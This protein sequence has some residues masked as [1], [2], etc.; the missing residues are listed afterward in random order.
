MGIAAKPSDAHASSGKKQSATG[1][2]SKIADP[3]LNEQQMVDDSIGIV[4]GS[5][6]KI[7]FAL[8]D[9]ELESHHTD[10]F[11]PGPGLFLD[12]KAEERI[13]DSSSSI[14]ATTTRQGQST[15]MPATFGDVGPAFED[16]HE[17][18]RWGLESSSAAAPEEPDWK[19]LERLAILRQE[20]THSR[21]DDRSTRPV[22]VLSP[23]P[24]TYSRAAGHPATVYH[25]SSG[26][27]STV[28]SRS[29]SWYNDLYRPISLQQKLPQK[30]PRPTWPP[31]AFDL[32]FQPKEPR[33]VP[34]QDDHS[35]RRDHLGRPLKGKG[36]SEAGT[37]G[38][39]DKDNDRYLLRDYDPYKRE[40]SREYRRQSGGILNVSLGI[41]QNY[42][43]TREGFPA[44][45]DLSSTEPPSFMLDRA[46]KDEAV[47]E[48]HKPI[49]N[50]R[51]D[52]SGQH[53]SQPN[54]STLYRTPIGPADAGRQCD[55]GNVLND[56]H[57]DELDPSEPSTATRSPS[58]SA[59]FTAPDTG[60][61]TVAHET[62]STAEQRDT[63]KGHSSSSE[64]HQPTVSPLAQDTMTVY[65]A[66]SERY[67]SKFEGYVKALAHNLYNSL[68][69]TNHDPED[70]ET[71]TNTLPRRLQTFA[72]KLSRDSTD[73]VHQD[74]KVFVY[75][76]RNA[77]A[78]CLKEFVK[79]SEEEESEEKEFIDM[80]LSEKMALWTRMEDHEDTSDRQPET[81]DMLEPIENPQSNT[82][83]FGLELPNLPS[84]TQA[85]LTSTAYSWLLGSLQADLLLFF[86]HLLAELHV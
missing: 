17:A 20:A 43:F 13:E 54:R 18:R 21:S 69:N 71:I 9:E 32:P 66:F 49:E 14:G 26:P 29:S 35:S 58:N 51:I 1:L 67:N 76:R 36:Y 59:C 24:K 53:V 27:R 81:L 25:P 23:L 65:S 56:Y 12:L 79:P 62:N 45:Q 10:K 33:K 85:V 57:E 39:Y 40:V 74:I 30:K 63:E 72:L 73:Q 19:I 5:V 46:P 48:I 55:N 86:A 77:I 28:P 83:Q 82:E 41:P 61:V 47:R 44:L 37:D 11:E 4:G 31:S 38:K 3:A 70:L 60:D 50:T 15:T 22:N 7:W 75:N 68:G 64:G 42:V 78:E 2:D 6:K 34:Q 52:N 16:I 84:Y 80:G 8:F